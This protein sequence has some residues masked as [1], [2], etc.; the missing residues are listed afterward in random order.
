M[1][2]GQFARIQWFGLSTRALTTVLEPDLVYRVSL[3]REIDVV[4]FAI[5]GLPSHPKQRGSRYPYEWPCRASSSLRRLPRGSSGHRDYF[6]FSRVSRLE[7]SQRL[8]TLSFFASGE[9]KACCRHWEDDCWPGY[10]S[11]EPGKDNYWPSPSGPAMPRSRAGVH[12]TT[13]MST[14][15]FGPRSR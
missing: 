12:T 13:Q 2:I 15:P 8:H 4:G 14:S 3:T 5:P 10:Q 11:S 7:Q 1:E 9:P 6:A